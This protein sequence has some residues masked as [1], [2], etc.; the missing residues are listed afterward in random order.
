MISHAGDLISDASFLDG[1]FSQ[2]TRAIKLNQ[3]NNPILK[4]YQWYNNGIIS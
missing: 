1:G 3:V 2:P 4:L